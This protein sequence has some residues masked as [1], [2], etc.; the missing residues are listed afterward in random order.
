MSSVCDYCH[1]ANI[2]AA[3]SC[4][5]CGAPVLAAA[6]PADFR[7]C[8]YCSRT[9]LALGSPACS[10]CGRRLP[11]SFLKA[12]DEDFHRVEK[13][14][15]QVVTERNEKETLAVFAGQTILRRSER[16]DSPVSD[17]INI[18]SDLLT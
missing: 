8:P 17:L 4:E 12:R 14:S 13:I 15:G 9:L 10:Y 11:D 5:H 7:H 2:D 1:G 16:S 6:E 3:T 18:V